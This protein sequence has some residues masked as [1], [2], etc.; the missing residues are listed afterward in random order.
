[1]T[2]AW[3]P[4]VRRVLRS[5]MWVI[6]ELVPDGL[7]ERMTPLLPPPEPR[8][9]RYPAPSTAPTCARSKGDDV[10]PSPADRG[11]PG[12]KH[13]L[14]CDAGGI[15]LAVTLTGGNRNDVTPS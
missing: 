3:Q 4:G 7:W 11:R 6:E 15:P 13:H 10:G 1:M 2:S 8:R 9:H 14:I 5:Q 12:S